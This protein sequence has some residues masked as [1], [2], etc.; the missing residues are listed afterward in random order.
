MASIS[1]SDFS[2]FIN[3]QIEA[4]EKIES[5]LWKLEALIAVA[6]IADRFHDFS[7]KLLHNYFSV[8]GDLIQEATNANQMSLDELMKQNVAY[9][10][11]TTA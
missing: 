4:Q 10:E 6:V 1:V 8:L 2:S 3:R 7:E 9:T 5:C 11:R